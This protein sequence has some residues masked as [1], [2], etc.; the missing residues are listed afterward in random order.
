MADGAIGREARCGV[1]R[2]GG[3]I[4]VSLMAAVACCRQRRVVVVGV[5]LR[6]SHGSVGAG[7]REGRVVV[8]KGRRCPRRGVVA[9]GAGG[10]EARRRMGRVRCSIPIRRVA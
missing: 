5:A 2:I 9:R 10:W 7:E 6:A 8:I 3:P 1:R 4:P